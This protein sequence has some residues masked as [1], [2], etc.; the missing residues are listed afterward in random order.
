MKYCLVLHLLKDVSDKLNL[1]F[2]K[3]NTEVL[4]LLYNVEFLLLLLYVLLP[5]RLLFFNL[6]LLFWDSQVQLIIHCSKRKMAKGDF[7][8][9]RT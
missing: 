9:C 4:V 6:I 7:Q 8:R 3:I 2:L 5:C 1:I